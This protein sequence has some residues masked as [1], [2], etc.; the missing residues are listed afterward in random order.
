MCLRYSTS[1]CVSTAKLWVLIVFVLVTLDG[2]QGGDR[3]HMGYLETPI[4]IGW[5]KTKEDMY[6]SLQT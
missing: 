3:V 6:T 5:S 4:L 2:R 1:I